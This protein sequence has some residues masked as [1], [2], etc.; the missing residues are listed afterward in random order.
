MAE[1]VIQLPVAASEDLIFGRFLERFMES[2]VH[3]VERMA[4]SSDAP[5]VMI[6]TDP[7]LGDTVRIVTFQ[8]AD[9][10][11]AFSMG[12]AQARTRSA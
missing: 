9:A 8:E 10:A 7:A 1:V 2:R 3:E 11:S 5:Y 6:H 4:E 12:W